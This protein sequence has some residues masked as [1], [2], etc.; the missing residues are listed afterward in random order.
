MLHL[1]GVLVMWI[2][3]VL[4]LWVIKAI[5]LEHDNLIFVAFIVYLLTILGVIRNP[6]LWCNLTR[7]FGC[8]HVVYMLSLVLMRRL[9]LMSV[10]VKIVSFRIY[11]WIVP[12]TWSEW[13][14]T[15]RP[16]ASQ[17][18][19]AKVTSVGQVLETHL[20]L[21]WRL[22]PACIT[23]LNIEGWTTRLF[24]LCDRVLGWGT[25]AKR[26]VPL[27]IVLLFRVWIRIY[28]RIF[29]EH[30]PIWMISSE[31]LEVGNLIL[32]FWLYFTQ[33]LCKFNVW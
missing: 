7:S 2:G 21:C 26:C 25:H 23:T 13:W 6:A 16:T 8:T 24:C 20:S 17:H 19:W 9:M 4:E 27:V 22:N 32:N 14:A 10:L 15:L 28:D 1:C 18:T 29:I 3:S 31:D 11:S 33:S 12:I 5:W 30:L